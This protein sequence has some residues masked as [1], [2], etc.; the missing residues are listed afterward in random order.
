M[1]N[2]LF[3]LSAVEAIER[4]KNRT[5]SPLE[6]M[7][8]VIQ[9]TAAT[10]A[11]VGAFTQTYFEEAREAAKKATEK[12]TAGKRTG[13][14]EGLPVAI[15][16][17][18]AVKGKLTSAGS[19][20]FQNNV[21]T[22]DALPVD[23]IK[24]AGGII[25][26]RT[27]ISELG[28]AGLT[29]N[30]LHPPTRCPWNTAYNSSGTSGGA[31]AALAAGSTVLANGS[32]YFGSIR[33]PASTCGVVGYK[34]ARGRNAVSPYFNIDWYDH[35]GPLARFVADCALFQNAMSGQHPDDL[36]SLPG[37]TRVGG[38]ETSVAG[39]R[40]ALSI[41]LGYVAIDPDVEAN[42]RRAA[43]TFHELGAT[44]EEV[45]LGWTAACLDAYR[46]HIAVVFG[47]WL[48]DYL[49]AHSHEMT[50]YAVAF[51]KTELSRSLLKS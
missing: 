4:F 7:D 16:E 10:E 35:D 34:P 27:N 2:D 1:S 28:T 30:L 25:H 29:G 6:L 9:R 51:A 24:K 37:R 8:A 14:L 17:D 50:D 33:V 42:T 39:W 23:R 48:E 44:V 3:A 38:K 31:A 26:A 11:A 22:A 20:I 47:T 21:A 36:F 46:N 12:F 43:E 18:K 13:P 5:L 45:D 49:P 19:K 15:K 40:V 32:D 41:D